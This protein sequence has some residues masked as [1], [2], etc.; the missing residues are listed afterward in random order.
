MLRALL[1]Q[2]VVAFN[3]RPTALNQVIHDHDVP[4]CG[5]ALLDLDDALGAIP[6]L[7]ADDLA[8]RS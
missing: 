4:A 2:N 3:E 5:L 7:G 1:L 8:R 6:H